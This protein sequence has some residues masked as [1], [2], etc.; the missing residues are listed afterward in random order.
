M[1]VAPNPF[2]FDKVF[3]ELQHIPETGNVAVIITVSCVFGIYLIF[4]LWVRKADQKDALKVG[5]SLIPKEKMMT[6]FYECFLLI[7]SPV[8]FV[9]HCR[10]AINHFWDLYGPGV[11]DTRLKYPQAFGLI[12][13][14]VLTCI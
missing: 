6:L 9:V 3:I 7:L 12:L 2:N 11:V 13:V 8:Y 4:I 1:F 14:P 5:I 10:S